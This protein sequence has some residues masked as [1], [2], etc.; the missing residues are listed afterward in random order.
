M[1]S[2][3]HAL[4][5]REL[6]FANSGAS[7]PNHTFLHNYGSCIST[8]KRL[9]C[10]QR[11]PGHQAPLIT[12]DWNH[13]GELLASAGDDSKIGVWDVQRS[14]SLHMM[15][16][17]SFL[18]RGAALS[19]F[20]VSR[21]SLV[22]PSSSARR[23]LP[24]CFLMLI[25]LS[26]AIKYGMLLRTGWPRVQLPVTAVSEGDCLPQADLVAVYDHLPAYGT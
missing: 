6:G 20:K 13:D 9:K 18:C 21:F 22:W 2:H 4:L 3:R 12:V 5:S 23:Q 26:C 24:N 16:T 11:L 25:I 14:R 10:L 8:I 17:V 19:A 7:Y 15:D 1:S